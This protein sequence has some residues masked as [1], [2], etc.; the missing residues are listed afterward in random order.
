MPG[1]VAERSGP[2]S[3]VVVLNDKRVR[4]CHV[5]HVRGDSM[6]RAVSDPSREMESQDKPP[7][8]PI[9]IPLSVSVPDP[10]L[11]PSVRP[12]NVRSEME[13]RE[14]QAQGEVPATAVDKALPIVT[15]YPEAVCLPFRRSSRVRKAP[16]R[17]IETI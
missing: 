13:S 8:S 15:Q 12:A 2:K 1:S 10:A 11:A 14:R 6:D 5:D 9:A 3:Y 4:K 7:D 17:L 16:D